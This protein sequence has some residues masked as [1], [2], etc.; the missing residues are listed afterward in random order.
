MLQPRC[1][2]QAA[3]PYTARP[4]IFSNPLPVAQGK[5]AEAEPLCKKSLAIQEK[6]L[7]PEHPALAALLINSAGMLKRQARTALF[8]SILILFAIRQCT[9]R[10]FD[11]KFSRVL[12][13]PVLSLRGT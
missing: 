13:L 12:V 10:I 11:Q 6:S 7:G 1:V 5:F 3:P 2:I 4:L 9:V 8:T